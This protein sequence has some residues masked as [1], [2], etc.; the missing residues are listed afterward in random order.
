MVEIQKLIIFRLDANHKVGMGHL[1]RMIRLSRLFKENSYRTKFLIRKNDATEKILSSKGIAYISVP[2]YFTE[3]QIINKALSQSRPKCW[4]FDI[5]DT[6]VGWIKRLLDK[7]VLVICIDDNNGKKNGSNLVINPIVGCWGNNKNCLKESGYVYNGPL[8]AILSDNIKKFRKNRKI[9]K[10]RTR[11]LNVGVSMGGSDTHGATVML[12]EA[13]NAVAN[14]LCKVHFYLGPSFDHIN[15]LNSEVRECVYDYAIISGAGNLLQSLD[16]MD[17]VICGGGVTLFE[18]A[19]MG[20][21]PLGF[22]NEIHEERTLS[23]FSRH[24]SCYNLGSVH[25]TNIDILKN[26]LS[27]VLNSPERLNDL[28]ANTIKLVDTEGINRVFN[29]INKCCREK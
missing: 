7:G 9:T 5:L 29:L 11:R 12:A 27:K 20:M 16:K 13:L 8:Y 23:Y 19:A 24:K 3:T 22:A 14:I 26:K 4:V 18:V 2:V 28:C 25:K 15:E 21:P 17:V 1:Y 6:N 10:Q